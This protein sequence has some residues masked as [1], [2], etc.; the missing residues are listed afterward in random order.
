M[1]GK[2]AAGTKGTKVRGTTPPQKQGAHGE[3][4]ARNGGAKKKRDGEGTRW[5][6]THRPPQQDTNGTSTTSGEKP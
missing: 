5:E 2:E 3:E 6:A 4:E 1:D